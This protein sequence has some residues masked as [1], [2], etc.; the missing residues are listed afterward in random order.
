MV[1]ANFGHYSA[2]IDDCICVAKIVAGGRAARQVGLP[3]QL[4]NSPKNVRWPTARKMG[5][6][7]AHWVLQT[8]DWDARRV[9]CLLG[10]LNF[11]DGLGRHRW[12]RNATIERI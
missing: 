7:I 9:R 2:M 12:A 5:N 1:F 8:T 10:R 3:G 4:G 11:G 6:V